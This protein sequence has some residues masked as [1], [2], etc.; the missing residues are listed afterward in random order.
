MQNGLLERDCDAHLEA[1][2]AIS[3][4]HPPLTQKIEISY[5]RAVMMT[6][7]RMNGLKLGCFFV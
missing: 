6:D 7:D 3:I 5:S 4:L 2:F 1:Y